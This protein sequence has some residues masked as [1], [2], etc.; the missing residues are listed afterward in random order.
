MQSP[1]SPASATVDRKRDETSTL[2]IQMNM[3]QPMN[4]ETFVD[5]HNA[6]IEPRRRL[7]E[8]MLAGMSDNDA[9]DRLSGIR[10][11]LRSLCAPDASLLLETPGG[12]INTHARYELIELRRD[13]LFARSGFEAL[14]L[15]AFYAPAVS[16]A[17]A[18]GVSDEL[19]HR[20]SRMTEQATGLAE[21]LAGIHFDAFISDRDGTVNGYCARYATSVQPAWVAI[22]LSR[23][24]HM[25]CDRAVLLTAG[26]MSGPGIADLST[27]RSDAAVLAASK[28][29]EYRLESGA[30]GAEV[31]PKR[32]MRALDH[33][34]ETVSRLHEHER[35]RLLPYIGSGLQ[36]KHGMLAV[37]YQDAA[38]SVPADLAESFRRD[39]LDAVAQAN[40]D[41]GRQVLGTEDTGREIEVSL[42]EGVAGDHGFDKGDGVAYLCGELGLK[43]EGRTV[44]VCGD[45]ESDIPMLE[46]VA[47]GGAHVY[48]VFA[49][50]SA[51]VRERVERLASEAVFVDSFEPLVAGLNMSVPE[52]EYEYD[53]L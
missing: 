34:A 40:S 15:P 39:V 10:R 35:Y 23:F 19:I 47:A 7:C 45:T 52:E 18:D 33:V 36:R 4:Y 17:S 29:R 38:G 8:G 48:A 51:D 6:S 43:L 3:H 14:T 5:T 46:R 31:L 22:A 20:S 27:M 41:A 11:T 9:R 24:I 44:L 1:Y 16:D 42:R 28:G 30:T 25:C 53:I 12:P 37:A 13:I 2:S 32:G 21:R 49:G 50:V 26:P